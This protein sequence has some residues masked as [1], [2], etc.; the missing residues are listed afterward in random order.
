MKSVGFSPELETQARIESLK[1]ACKS[2]GD[3]VFDKDKASRCKPGDGFLNGSDLAEL[4]EVAEY[5]YRFIKNIDLDIDDRN[6]GERISANRHKRTN[7]ALSNITE[8]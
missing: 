3:V 2:L 6:Q 7:R 8:G 4:F 5:N 1:L